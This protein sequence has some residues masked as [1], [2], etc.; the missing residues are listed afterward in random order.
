MTIE[1]LK[2]KTQNVVSELL[3]NV[4][5]QKLTNDQDIFYLGLNSINAMTLIFNLQEAFGV[6]FN[7][8]EINFDNFRTIDDIVKLIAR[9]TQA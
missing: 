8:A 9:K 4:D 1:E 2:L 7:D 6:T 3:P 5:S